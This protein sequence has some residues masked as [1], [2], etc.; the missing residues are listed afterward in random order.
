M[1][2]ETIDAQNFLEPHLMQKMYHQSPKNFVRTYET[3]E[4]A[5]DYFIVMDYFREGTLIDLLQNH[6]ES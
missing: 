2:N 6:H 1:I 5:K 4:S 3:F